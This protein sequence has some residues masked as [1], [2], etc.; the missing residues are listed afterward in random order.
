MSQQKR[1]FSELLL[2]PALLILASCASSFRPLGAQEIE[3][4]IQL[5]KGF[6]IAVFA[7]GLNRRARFMAFDRRG[8]LYVTLAGTGQVA[9]LPDRDKDGRADAVIP[10]AAGLKRPHGIDIRDGWVYVGETDGVVRLRDLD[11]DLRA[12]VKEQ[13]V[14]GLPTGGHWSRTVRF[15]PDGKLYVSVGSS[16]NVCVEDDPRRAAVVRYEPDGRGE[17]VFARGL[18]NSVGITWRPETGEMWAV[19]NGRDWLGDNLPPEEINVIR[20]GRHYGWPHCY[21]KGTPDPQH[22]KEDFCAREAE[23]PAFEMQAHSAPLGLAFYT[24][25]AFPAAYRGDLFIAFHGS[26][27]RTVPTGY[28]VVRVKIKDGKPAGIEDFAAGWLD[29]FQVHGRPTDVI[30]GPDGALYVSDDKADRI[31]RISHVPR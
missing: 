18:R 25:T 7:D 12:D 20:A 24:G 28:K 23:P 22:G 9:V 13:I 30:V 4:R 17:A 15:G 21:G 8:N 19:D 31:Y 5:P 26:W 16:C 3:R 14:R 6:R 11:G 10:F 29:G 2:F 1:R 27:N